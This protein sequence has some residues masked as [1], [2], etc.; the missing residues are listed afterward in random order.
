MPPAEPRRRPQLNWAL[1]MS[2][3]NRI[4]YHPETRAYYQRQ[5]DCGKANAKP[6][7]SSNGT[8]PG[9]STAPFT[10]ATT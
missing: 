6:S 2:A 3:L 4:R 7:A 9:A 1:H 10:A 8:S 5:L